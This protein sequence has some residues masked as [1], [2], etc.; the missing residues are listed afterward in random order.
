MK[1]CACG[2]RRRGNSVIEFALTFTF[3]FPLFAGTFQFGYAM[4]Q[5]NKLVNAVRAGARYASVETYDSATSTPSTQFV[6]QVKNVVIYGDP[7]PPS[8]AFPV[9][10]GLTSDNVEV[11]VTF[12]RSVPDSITVRLRDYRLD[13]AF[14]A[15]RL[16]L[17]RATFSYAGRYAPP[18]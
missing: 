5:Y 12:V 7:N 18:V 3:L 8:G 6:S 2:R 13:A 11:V 1:A 4:F 17:P 15:I 16:N 10:P 9:V 14:G